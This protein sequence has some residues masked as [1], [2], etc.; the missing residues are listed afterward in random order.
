MKNSLLIEGI[1]IVLVGLMVL[2]AL[3]FNMYEKQQRQIDQLCQGVFALAREQGATDDN[4][5]VAGK[6]Y[7]FFFADYRRGIALVGEFNDR[8]RYDKKPQL[9]IVHNVDERILNEWNNQ[10]TEYGYKKIRD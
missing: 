7:C 9:I 2:C 5:F 4:G 8:I 1:L 3:L 6:T 10:Q